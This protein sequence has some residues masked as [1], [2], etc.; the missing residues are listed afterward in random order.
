LTLTFDDTTIMT[1]RTEIEKRVYQ[2]AEKTLQTQKYV[3]SLDILMGL[4]WLQPVHVADWRKGKI[5]YLEKMIQGSLSKI[6]YAMKCFRVWVGK[7]SLKA[8]ET[9]Y[10]VKTN[11]PQQALRF[12]KFN[13]PQIEKNYRTHYISSE[14]SL[15]KQENLQT[16]LAKAPDLIVYMVSKDTHCERC[17][18]ELFRSSLLFKEV[19]TA[20][21]MKCAGLSKLAFLSSGDA[22]LTLRAK[23]YSSKFAVVVRFSKA[24]K[25]YERQG[26]LVETQALEKAQTELRYPKPA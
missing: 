14:L 17:K 20:L 12:S 4:G 2:I 6:S 26:L 5:D 18:K 8:S 25:R 3:C 10:L 21:C 11:G 7:K 23:K 22:K 16:K 1:N 19:N 13:E 24:R 9:A 15:R